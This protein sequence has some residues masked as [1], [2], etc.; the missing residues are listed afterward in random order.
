[1]RSS[2][3][4]PTTL[5]DCFAQLDELAERKETSTEKALIC[6]LNNGAT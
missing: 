5:D 4:F 1:M 3:G 2:G 6:G